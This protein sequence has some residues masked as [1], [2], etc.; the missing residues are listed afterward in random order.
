MAI[1]ILV[2][3]DDP[4]TVQNVIHALEDRRA[5]VLVH[6]QDASL[7][8]AAREASPAAILLDVS[9]GQD[10]AMEVSATLKADEAFSGVPVFSLGGALED[11]TSYYEDLSSASSVAAEI[12]AIAEL[13][14][15]FQGGDAAGLFESLDQE[16]D[17]A[18]ALGP[19]SSEPSGSGAA[20]PPSAPP[21]NM[22]PPPVPTA[23]RDSSAAIP[24]PGR[25]AGSARPTAASD[26]SGRET[27]SLRQD[28]LAR[29][30][31]ILD[32]RSRVM[33]LQ[34]EQLEKEEQQ[35]QTLERVAEL[36]QDLAAYEERV[37][38]GQAEIEGLTQAHGESA[39]SHQAELQALQQSVEESQAANEE[40]RAQNT[41]L[42]EAIEAQRVEFEAKI[43]EAADHAELLEQIEA[44]E[45]EKDQ[46][47]TH[48]NEILAITTE[49][50]EAM[51]EADANAQAYAD[52]LEKSEALIEALRKDLGVYVEAAHR[53]YEARVKNQSELET[54]LETIDEA[55]KSL[56]QATK[57]AIDTL[58]ATNWEETYNRYLEAAAPDSTEE[59]GGATD[60]EIV[61]LD[62]GELEEMDEA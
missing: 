51:N 13:T 35:V 24:I 10:R 34:E 37:A 16:M 59:D 44:L 28:V 33:E 25:R 60:A 7:L 12:L 46:L 48:R 53:A 8:I 42:H 5:R 22:P 32:L 57:E 4:S 39:A 30:R 26:S 38:A 56:R 47:I 14:S 29:D 41:A 3:T 19:V 18:S 20:R 31:E 27:L 52:K 11:V 49:L 23:R 21:K 54:L 55:R 6:P 43:Q 2:M 36:E 17:F 40:L 1:Q 62:A 45:A 61:E 50:E 15:G 9:A 58:P